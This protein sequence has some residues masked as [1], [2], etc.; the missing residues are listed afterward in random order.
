MGCRAAIV[1]GRHRFQWATYA[2][3]RADYQTGTRD[4]RPD[5]PYG[6]GLEFTRR[7]QANRACEPHQRR[8]EQGPELRQHRRDL[9][10]M[11]R[12]I[13]ERIN[14]ID[15]RLGRTT[16]RV[17]RASARPM[18][19]PPQGA[20]AS[21]QGRQRRSA[22]EEPGQVLS[23]FIKEAGV[24]YER[25]A[26]IVGVEKGTVFRHVKGT[27]KIRVLVARKYAEALTPLLGRTISAAEIVGH[28]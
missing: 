17:S 25:L 16:R 7:A 2:V 10:E 14:A 23:R 27:R 12:A 26:E 5:R 28:V 22:H 6:R 11:R 1:S 19:R 8:Q 15:Q 3:L 13:Q 9:T 18:E 4:D 24:S 20:P 21:S